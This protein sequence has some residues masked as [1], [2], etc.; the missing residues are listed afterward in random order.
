MGLEA[1]RTTIDT[2]W[3]GQVTSEQTPKE[4]QGPSQVCTW[5][6]NIPDKGNTNRKAQRWKHA[7]LTVGTRNKEARAME[8]E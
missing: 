5:E 7:Q 6:K 3:S 2:G 4:I 8:L 1:W